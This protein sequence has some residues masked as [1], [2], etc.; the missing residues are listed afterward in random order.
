MAQ[1]IES[2]KGSRV[3]GTAQ[4]C[5]RSFARSVDCNEY[6]TKKRK[7]N[8]VAQDSQPKASS[9]STQTCKKMQRDMFTD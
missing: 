9:L 4:V 6:R 2:N 5:W 1:L 3:D 7:K 8:L